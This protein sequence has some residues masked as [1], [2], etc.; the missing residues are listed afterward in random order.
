MTALSVHFDSFLKDRQYLKNVSPRTLEWYR[1]AFKQFAASQG[2]E[3]ISQQSA[4][5]FVVALRERGVIAITCNNRIIALNAFLR[6]MHQEGNLAAPIRIPLQKV[7]QK[8]VPTLTDS[9]LRA[10]LT[11]KPKQWGQRR[12][13][14]LANLLIDTG[15]RIEEALGLRV[16]DIDLDNMLA[17]VRGKGRKERIVPFS[18]LGGQ[19][20]TGHLSTLQN[21]P[22][23]MSGI[24]AE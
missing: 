20:K 11:F 18:L 24:E 9:Q 6:W 10:L 4:R 12:A 8:T 16:T 21:R 19:G 3:P 1:L 23:P 5:A 17:K 14:V 13:F 2:A 22:F 15:V 7:E